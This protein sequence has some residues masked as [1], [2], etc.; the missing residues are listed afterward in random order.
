MIGSVINDV[1]QA[2][3]AWT[4]VC[5]ALQVSLLVETEIIDTNLSGDISKPHQ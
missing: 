1:P 2:A 5:L 3:L 4:G